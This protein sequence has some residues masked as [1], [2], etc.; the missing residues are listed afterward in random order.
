MASMD[1]QILK[2]AKEIVV[3]FI[4]TGRL[5]PTAFGEVFQNVYQTVATTV[6]A[7]TPPEPAPPEKSEPT[8]GKKR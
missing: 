1:E 8:K 5:S 7:A 4:E 2:T 6:A 3:K